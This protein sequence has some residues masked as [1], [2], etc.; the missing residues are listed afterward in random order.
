MSVYVCRKEDTGLLMY[1]DHLPVS[2]VVVGDTSRG[3][4]EAKLTIGPLTCRGDSELLSFSHCQQTN[5]HSFC[6]EKKK[7][8]YII[9]ET[10]I[11]SHTLAVVFYRELLECS[12]L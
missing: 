10:F 9:K 5:T 11:F 8:L 4:S 3:G 1:K 12:I 2:K 7:L 6:S